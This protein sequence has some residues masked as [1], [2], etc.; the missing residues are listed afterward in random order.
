MANFV[1][2]QHNVNPLSASGFTFS[3][4]KIPELTYFAQEVTLPSVS[5]PP[6]EIQTP[7][8][9]F[10][11]SGVNLQYSDLTV[12]FIVDEDMSNYLAIYK[13]MVGL[14][15]PEAR[16]QFSDFIAGS[17]LNEVSDGNLQIL[18]SSNN[19]IRNIVFYDLRPI[20]LG[21]LTMVTNQS[22]ITYL[23]CDV[24]FNY[25]FFKFEGL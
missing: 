16:I 10:Y 22:D 1:A 8:S 15:F 25:S 21:G 14:G 4:Q 23:T 5:L 20:D 11:T 19:V 18:S 13:W 6:A 12:S 17:N 2:N 3:I 24:T 7:L 9:T